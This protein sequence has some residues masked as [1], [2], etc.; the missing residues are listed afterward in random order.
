[1]PE[2]AGGAAVLADPCDIASI[3]SGLLAVVQ[4]P[5]RAAVMRSAVWPA[6]PNSTGGTSHW[7]NLAIYRRLLADRSF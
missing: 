7:P 1:M 2:V 4:S 5:A 6:Q 3:A